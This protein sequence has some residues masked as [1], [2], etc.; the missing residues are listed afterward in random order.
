MKGND[1]KRRRAR[2]NTTGDEILM[3]LVM[4]G[5]LFAFMFIAS[6]F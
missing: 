1:Q 3:G 6:F 4:I 2:M 5:L